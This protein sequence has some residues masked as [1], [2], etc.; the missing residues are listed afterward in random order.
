MCS[1]H[2]PFS[3]QCKVKKYGS[4]ECS[5]LP[6]QNRPGLASPFSALG[7]SFAVTT[8]KEGGAVCCRAMVAGAEWVWIVPATKVCL[9]LLPQI[10][11]LVSYKL[12]T[13]KLSIK[14]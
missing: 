3:E 9:F 10:K 5:L 1:S 8:P 4:P 7:Q 2:S 13:S 14:I 12:L 11:F 6:N